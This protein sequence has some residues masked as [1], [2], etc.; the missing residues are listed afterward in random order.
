MKLSGIGRG[1]ILTI[2]SFTLKHW[3]LLLGIVAGSKI[4]PISMGLEQHYSYLLD[5]EVLIQ[6]MK[7]V[8]DF[9]LCRYQQDFM[10]NEI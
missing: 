5:G 1:S 2:V 7:G 3:H 10:N 8:L 4:H 9:M 6:G